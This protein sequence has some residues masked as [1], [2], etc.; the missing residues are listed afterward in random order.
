M[1]PHADASTMNLHPSEISTAISSGAHAVL[2]VDGAGWHQTSGSL[3]MPDNVTLLHLPPY[4]PEL[5]PV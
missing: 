2:V 5:N 1:L 3:R 4:N